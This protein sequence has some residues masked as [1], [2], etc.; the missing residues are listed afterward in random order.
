[1]TD[2][3][4]APPPE[5]PAPARRPLVPVFPTVELWVE[6][7]FGPTFA[8][9]KPFNWCPQWRK[10][11]EARQVLTV[12]WRTW[13]EAMHEGGANDMAVWFRD[14]AYPLLDRLT[15]EQGTFTGC[16]W[17]AE[18]EEYRHHPEVV[19]LTTVLAS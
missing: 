2:V 19:D 3:P 7:Y 6:N 4:L 15:A 18:D 13:E 10:H 9:P 14:Y 5:A 12:L 16:D 17:H 11:Q 1:M 8:R